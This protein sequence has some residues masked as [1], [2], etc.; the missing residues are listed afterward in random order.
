MKIQREVR[1]GLAWWMAFAQGSL[2]E[3]QTLQWL[4]DNDENA[5]QNAFI[6]ADLILKYLDSKGV[7]VCKSPTVYGLVEHERLIEE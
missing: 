1:E 6:I 5:F 3:D 2:E 4:H 7:R